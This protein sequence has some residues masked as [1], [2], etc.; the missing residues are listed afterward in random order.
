M[1]EITKTKPGAAPGMKVTGDELGMAEAAIKNP[2]AAPVVK[3]TPDDLGWALKLPPTK[4][5]VV[6]AKEE[7]KK[8]E[9]DD[10]KATTLNNEGVRLYNQKDFQGALGKFVQ[11]REAE[12]ST[13]NVSNS[14]HAKYKIGGN[15]EQVLEDVG[16]ALRLN[17]NNAHALN[18]GGIVMAGQ[19][20]DE[21]A[22]GLYEAAVAAVESGKWQAND[23][24]KATMIANRDRC[25]LRLQEKQAAARG[26]VERPQ[27]NT[28]QIIP[29][30][31][32]EESPGGG[33]RPTQPPR[34]GGQERQHPQEERE[35]TPPHG[36]GGGDR[37]RQGPGRQRQEE[38]IDP[39]TLRILKKRAKNLRKYE[40]GLLRLLAT[41]ERRGL[42]E[43]GSPGRLT[44]VGVWDTKKLSDSND[45]QLLIEAYKRFCPVSTNFTA[46]RD[47]WVANMVEAV[48][49]YKPDASG[50]NRT[51]L[52]A[53]A[54]M[55][56]I[57]G[58]ANRLE[59]AAENVVAE[60]WNQERWDLPLGS[61]LG[62]WIDTHFWRGAGGAV[63]AEAGMLAGIG[64]SA[65]LGAT[66]IG[67]PIAIGAAGITGAIAGGA[68]AKKVEEHQ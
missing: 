51:G 65:A 56:S 58:N 32:E 48:A 61:S 17:E 31:S 63:G 1:V 29:A 23:Q 3:V 54:W 11:S 16:A 13:V 50:N 24:D 28:Q 44:K 67:V 27:Q 5:V 25:L 40:R 20:Q 10:Q 14:A 68:T 46:R 60:I 19:G 26:Q 18:L 2:G 41:E 47:Q 36:G 4:N 6:P 57:E 55:Y 12:A 59:K 33:R 9:G 37:V 35:T 66:G 45:V 22:L 43:D 49:D 53:K 8:T 64:L 39:T 21:S 7:R 52:P 30:M 38:D 34:G 42:N 62:R 15:A